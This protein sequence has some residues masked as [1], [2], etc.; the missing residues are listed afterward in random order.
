M[1]FSGWV[2]CVPLALGTSYSF[3]DLIG[4]WVM[5]WFKVVESCQFSIDVVRKQK[6]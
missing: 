2:S 6:I 4:V 5:C 3:E 1:H